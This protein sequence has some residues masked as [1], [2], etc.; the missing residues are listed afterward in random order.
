MRLARMF[1][2]V[3]LCA[4]AAV[5][6]APARA[7]STVGG[8][9]VGRSGTYDYS[10]SVVQSGQT[11]DFWWCGGRDAA[12]PANYS[13]TIKHQQYSFAG[14]VHITVAE[15]TVL[16]E[17]AGAWDSLYVCNP[18]V[19]AG[20]FV[21]PLGDG[22]TYGW[23]LYYVGTSTRGGTDNSIGVAF[24]NDGDH[25]AK[26]PGP[27]LADAPSGGVYYGLGQPNAYNPGGG[28]A[29][30]L[31]YEDTGASGVSHFEV[32]S[33]DGVHFAA[34]AAVTAVGL[35]S[36]TPSWGGVAYD[37]V[38]GRWYAAFNQDPT[39]PPSTTGGV[40]ERGQ[41]GVA[42]YATGD[43]SA[44]PWTALD[45]VDTNLTGY[46]SNFLA[47]LLRGADGALYGPLL[48]S[49]ELYA[50]TSNPRPSANATA[51]QRG[52]SG[53]FNN[54]DIAWS[55]WSPLAPTRALSRYYSSILPTHEVTTGWVDTPSFHLESVLG[56]LYEAP[57]GQFTRPL[58]GC[59]Q[60]SRDYFISGD[61]ACESQLVLGLDGYISPTPGPGLVELYRCYTGTDHFVS[62]SASCENR[63]TEEVLGWAQP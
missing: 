52:S 42:L 26:Y 47:G 32:S 3:A 22:V 30:T 20:S 58:Y 34:P 9:V 40:T 28:S 6:P 4:C 44:G 39:R 62:T 2:A 57:S 36:P 16:G 53:A 23:A 13:D 11:Q 51:A 48:P 54:W 24:S 5:V 38:G 60:G 50:S 61:A 7:S 41:A 8:F 46:E 35:P 18:S 14:G 59:V 21:D 45:T 33:A 10:P 37:P 27:V 19:V 63:T 1:A 49:V 25:W 56:H 43:L 29:V 17:S 31:L 15:R 55:A 12:D